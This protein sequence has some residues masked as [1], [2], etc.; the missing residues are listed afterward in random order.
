MSKINLK[1]FNDAHMEELEEKFFDAEGE[2]I[3]DQ[4]NGLVLEDEMKEEGELVDKRP[5][6]IKDLQTYGEFKKLKG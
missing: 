1:L 4:M 5:D 2:N 6:Q 3:E